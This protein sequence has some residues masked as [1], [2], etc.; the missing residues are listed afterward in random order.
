MGKIECQLIH[1]DSAHAL[2]RCCAFR[3]KSNLA[4]SKVCIF[5]DHARHLLTVV[6]GCMTDSNGT[7]KMTVRR[8]MLT[9]LVLHG[10]VAGMISHGTDFTYN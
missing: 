9:F 7:A 8:N 3:S 6:L 4:L 2:R 5:S 1:S 10:D